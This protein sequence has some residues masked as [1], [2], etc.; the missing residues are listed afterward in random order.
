M[1][2]QPVR[3]SARDSSPLKVRFT[4]K[5]VL[6]IFT[7]LTVVGMICTVFSLSIVLQFS[8][9]FRIPFCCSCGLNIHFRYSFPYGFLKG[10]V[11]DDTLISNL[12]YPNASIRYAPISN[13]CFSEKGFGF[14]R[15]LHGRI[16]TCDA[17]PPKEDSG[18]VTPA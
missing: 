12:I 15:I 13:A 7:S 1:T 10:I 4:L 6:S 18:F 2:A 3:I 17:C 9:A 16:A 8:K 5:T 11:S 14:S